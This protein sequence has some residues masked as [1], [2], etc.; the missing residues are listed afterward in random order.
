[1]NSEGPVCYGYVLARHQCQAGTVEAGRRSCRRTALDHQ[2]AEFSLAVGIFK[3]QHFNTGV[4][5]GIRDFEN[6]E[7]EDSDGCRIFQRM[8]SV[9][10]P[11]QIFVA[12]GTNRSTAKH[13]SYVSVRCSMRRSCRRGKGEKANGENRERLKARSLQI[14][15]SSPFEVRRPI[16]NAIGLSPAI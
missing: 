12:E 16:L 15:P 11:S 6:L 14:H 13:V 9:L 4:A 1:M 5:G 2:A 7:C 10:D 8:T 3:K